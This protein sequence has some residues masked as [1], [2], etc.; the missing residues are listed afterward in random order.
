MGLVATAAT[1]IA[2][3]SAYSYRKVTEMV[4]TGMEKLWIGVCKDLWRGCIRDTQAVCE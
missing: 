4:Q 2:V 1:G 3:Y